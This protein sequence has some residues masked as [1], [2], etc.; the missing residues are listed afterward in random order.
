M[1]SYF[2]TSYLKLLL[3]SFLLVC[4][5]S[6]TPTQA[7]MIR[8]NFIVKRSDFKGHLSNT[9]NKNKPRV[10]KE[11]I[12][13]KGDY[14]FLTTGKKKKF[15]REEHSY[16]IIYKKKHIPSMTPGALQNRFKDKL[17]IIKAPR[18]TKL[19][20]FKIKKNQNHKNVISSLYRADPAISFIS[21]VISS[22][23]EGGEL[24]VMPSI[25]VSID[26]KVDQDMAMSKLQSHNLSLV[27]GLTL[28]D[29]EFEMH[30]D[31]Q[32]D[33]IGRVFELVRTVAG[34]PFIKWAEPNFIASLQTQF[35]PD[36][37]LFNNQWHLHN[38]GQNGAAVDA[39][40]DAPEGWDV[41]QG[42][43]AVIAIYDDGVDTYHEDLNIW[44]NPGETGGGKETN[45]IDDDGNGYIDDYHGWDFNFYDNDP[46][47]SSSTDNHG[48]SVAG[49]AGAAGN[50]NMGVSGISPGASILPVR[51]NSGSCADFADAMRYAGKYADAVNNSWTINACNSSLDA[52][53]SDVVNGN[54]DG[55]RRGSLGTPVLFAAGN[56]ASGWI[57]FILSGVPK[58]T[59]TFEW[60]F[61]KD[62]YVS[63]GYDTV[64][65]DDISWPGSEITDF[66]GENVGT[67]PNG[68]ASGGSSVWT[69][70]NDGIH[71]RGASGNS[72][73]AGTI[74]D[75]Q[76]T[77]LYITKT[78][79]RG[80]LTFWAWVSSEQDYDLFEFY[81]N[82]ILQ[83]QYSP[84]QY[85]HF[86]YV[87]YPASNPDTIA[88]GASN[89]GVDSGEEERS[90]YSQFG[91]MLDIV[92]PS[93]GGSLGITTTD[94]MGASGYSNS[95]Y[96]LDFGGTS[97]A[98]PLVS[99]IVASIIMQYPTLTA[100]EVREVLRAGAEKIGPYAYPGDKNDYYG[101]G[102]ANLFNSL[103]A[104]PDNDNDGYSICQ[105]DCN[106][107]SGTIH[108]GASEICDNLDNNCNGF[109]DDNLTRPTTCGVGNCTGNIGTETCTSGAWG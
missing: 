92:A 9:N 15:L 86:N 22:K 102:R 58:G 49:V 94:R 50:N 77:S 17:D 18:L 35:I 97:S 105:N 56:D 12:V 84:G 2:F 107:Q 55:A 1:H 45:G 89:D 10:N 98:T 109:V 43:G 62:L 66:T 8:E 87:G 36:D 104:C 23:D 51:M 80:D 70:V 73:K 31:E 93:S 27:S 96:T 67:I 91:S 103:T 26:D 11:D 44:S 52:A 74:S 90:H 57:K 68:F 28:S 34:L 101:Y 46:N 71:A 24:A 16:F 4:L 53:I 59:Y 106:D 41:S 78:V 48:T 37:P 76:F 64:W 83:F 82:G 72:V 42:S 85:G 54:I 38:T 14:Y 13:D 6:A 21:Q 32:V 99:G 3:I 81:I 60:S 47:P 39:D 100:S 7:E 75:F 65:L 40:V 33:D 25:I 79:K 19:P 5:I 29:T 61:S 108:P 88:V 95:N 63:A 30:I 69:V 20:K